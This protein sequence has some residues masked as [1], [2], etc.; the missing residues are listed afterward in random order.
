MFLQERE[1]ADETA[2]SQVE[3]EMLMTRIN[4]LTVFRESNATLRADCEAKSKRI[5]Q[6]EAKLKEAGA[7]LGPTKQELLVAKAELEARD[8]Q[9]ARVQEDN[10]KWQERNSQLMSKVFHCFPLI[11]RTAY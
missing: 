7:E 5:S 1:R 3:H 2:T 4:E 9:I 10:H 8:A 6:I 11:C